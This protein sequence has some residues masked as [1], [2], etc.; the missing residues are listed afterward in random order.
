MAHLT[1]LGLYA[2]Q[3]RGQ[4]SAGIAVSDGE[5]IT[6]VKDMGLVTQVFD[7]RRLAPLDGHLAIGHDRYST[8]G[9]SSWRNAQPVYRSVGDAGFALGHNGNLTNTAELAEQLGM[10]PGMLGDPSPGSTPPPTPR[11]S[12]S[13]SPTSTRTS[14][15]LRRPR[16]R[17]SRSSSVLPRLAGRLLVRADGRQPTSSA[18]AIRTASGRSCSAAST[19]R[20][21]ARERD[22]GAR[23]RRR[24][25]RPRRRSRARWSSSTRRACASTSSRDPTRSSACSSSS[26]SRVPTRRCTA[27]SVHAA[28][29][30][31]G[32]ELARQAPVDADMVMPVP[33][34][35]IPAAQGYARR[36]GHPVRRR[37]GEEPL[38]RPHV[39]P[40]EPEAT[41]PGCA[42]QA[43][44]AAREHPRQ[45]PRRRRRLDRPRHHHHA[46]SSRCCARPA[47]PRCTSACRRRR[48]AG[49]AS[50]AW[51]PAGAPSSSPPTCRSARSATSSGSTR[52]PTSISTASIRATGS[53]RRVVLHG[54]PHRR[55]PG[56]RA[57]TP[58]R[59]TC[60]RSAKV[61]ATETASP[62]PNAASSRDRG[63][64]RRA[65][66]AHL[67]R[68]RRRHRGG[69]EGRRADQGA[70]A[71]D[72]PARGRRR[73]R[74]FRRAVRARRC[75]YRD[76]LLVSSTD[77]VGT[78]SVVAQL[79]GRYD[80]IGIDC[81]AMSVDD[82]AAQG[83]EPLFFL[84]YI[85][86]GKLVPEEVDEIVAGVADGCRRRGCALLGGEMSEHPGHPG[87]RRVRPRRV[88]GRRGRA[89][90]VLPADV[91]RRRR[92]RRVRE[93]GL[94]CNGYSL[95][96][97]ALLDRAGR[98]LDG[99]AWRGAHHSLGDE[100][101]ARA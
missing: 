12:P 89:A 21:G 62:R 85:S 53:P 7:E 94:R 70:R 24:A 26:T 84:D 16:P 66:A 41:R 73:H 30:R 58:T 20:L 25:L 97:R 72:V 34:S 96:R 13:S 9:S 43:Q 87:A 10:L 44:P 69:R 75:R 91:Q 101:L 11:S 8:T 57:R 35:G 51:T 40:A 52:S 99:P 15:A 86:I 1:Y 31:M 4:E 37:P 29:Q 61:R 38:R 19:R 22:R 54:V 78:K 6:V 28:R 17:A 32:E 33:E 59:S 92:D 67:R 36:V 60:S 63:R 14:P 90:R 23:H 83:A 27:S 76:P 74:R 55:V 71:L 50:T 18:C 46:R 3:H 2:L 82:I 65:R 56:A 100:L 79:A 5:T 88:R 81:V 64:D 93:P 45:A 49:P 98:A 48:T 47:R 80:T 42:A 77:G 95:A 68:R 39:H